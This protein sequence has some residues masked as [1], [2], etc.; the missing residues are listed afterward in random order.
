MI[1]LF[2]VQISA[3]N[4]MAKLAPEGMVE[5]NKKCPA[6]ATCKSLSDLQDKCEAHL[7]DACKS[8]VATYKKLLP[9]YD[10]QREFDATPKEKYI[11]SAI[12]LCDNGER[13]LG[14]LSKMETPEARKLFGSTALQD[15]L[16]GDA[17]ERYLAKSRKLQKQLQAK[18]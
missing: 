11:V 12:W 9:E 10:C 6:P 1:A 18:H 5:F 14:F 17:A 15:S 13:A 3:I 2:A 4:A 8:F 16:D 7:K